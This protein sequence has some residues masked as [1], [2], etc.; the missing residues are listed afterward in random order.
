[1]K[2]KNLEPFCMY[3]EEKQYYKDDFTVTIKRNHFIRSD[4]QGRQYKIKNFER[5][6]FTD[7]RIYTLQNDTNNYCEI[8]VE[9]T[10]FQNFIF[11]VMHFERTDVY[12]VLCK[13]LPFL[14]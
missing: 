5:L 4:Y 10:A 6:N 12:S 8:S 7:K 14:K 1:M 11:N 13:I 3:G 2:I 9:L